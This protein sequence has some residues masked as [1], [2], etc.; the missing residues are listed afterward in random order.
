M[1]RWSLLGND[2]LTSAEPQTDL[3]F[4]ARQLLKRWGVIFRDLLSREHLAP[5][6]RDLLRIY[7]YLE[8]RGEIRGGRFVTGFT[9]EQFALP[10]TLDALRSL[11][12]Q[13]PSGKT[14]RIS[15]ADPLNLQGILLPGER[16]LP[17]PESFLYYRDGLPVDDPGSI[18]FNGL[19][20]SR[21]SEQ[22]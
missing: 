7:R 4:F 6:W 8:A 18:Y 9:G 2:D 22:A 12:R 1:G 15:A 20:R 19:P 5:P 10:E 11:R 13:A 16:L 21:V 17:H 14:V 3:E